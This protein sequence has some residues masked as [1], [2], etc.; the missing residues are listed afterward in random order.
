MQ[1]LVASFRWFANTSLARSLRF[2][3][4][5]IVL[6]ASLPTIALLFLTASQQRTDAL[7][8]GQDEVVRL[9]RLAANDQG[10]EMDRVQRELL[11]LSRLPE[12]RGGDSSECT[13]LFQS[14]VADPDNAIYVD[15]R[16]INDA[17]EVICRTA[18]MDAAYGHA[19]RDTYP[20]SSAGIFY[21]RSTVATR[22]LLS[23]LLG[24]VRAWGGRRGMQ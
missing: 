8:A 1:R 9:A 14:L 6:L 5:S 18:W 3:L 23:S 15:L 13:A 20:C 4:I 24:M 10:R 22:A 12:V 11:L 2:R 21:A 7:E 19:N 16:V 17:G